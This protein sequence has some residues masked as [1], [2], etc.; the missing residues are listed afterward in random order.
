MDRERRA[1]AGPFCHRNEV[2]RETPRN[3]LRAR[4]VVDAV[5]EEEVHEVP[6]GGARDGSER[7][8][9]HE[10]RAVTVQHEDAAVGLRQREAQ[11][12]CRRAAHETDAAD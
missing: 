8:Q 1:V 7:A 11:A 2:H 6:R 4:G 12:K 10:E 5:L 3:P 9:L